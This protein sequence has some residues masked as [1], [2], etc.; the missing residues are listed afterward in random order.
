MRHLLT[1]AL[2]LLSFPVAAAPLSREE[3]PAPLR[4]W[5]SWVLRGHE[6]QTCPFYD[7]R[8]EREC[9][10]PGALKLT[11]D[12]SSGRFEQSWRVYADSRVLL[13]GGEQWP[14][15]V[16]V[17][18]VP[19]IVG[20]GPSILL[21][22]GS[23]VVSG[24]FS[25]KRLPE[26]LEVP[27]QTGLLALTVRGQAMPFPPRDDAGRLWLQAKAQPVAPKEQSHLE[28]SVHR[29]LIDE[30][31]AQLITRI[32]LKVSGA[33]REERLAR[34]L[35]EGFSPMSLVSPLPARLDGDGRLHPQARAG[36]WDLILV[37]RR[38]GPGDEIRM[39]KAEGAWDLDEA[40]VFEARPELRQADLE[41]APALD[42][43]QTELPM[44]WRSLPAYLVRP[45]D[46]LKLTQRR[47]GDDPPSPD[48][49]TQSREIWLD[50]DG[51]GYSARDRIAG[52]LGKSW[53]LEAA[54]ETKLG[55][56]AE[57]GL[58]QFLTALSSGGS[59]GLE[60]RTR[61]V[62]VE[63]DSRVEGRLRSAA[64]WRHDFESV[65]AVLHLPPGWRVFHASGADQASPTWV[66][67]WS[68]LDFFLVLV[69]AAAFLRLYGLNWG[70]AGL[71]GLGLSWHETGA[72]RWT[73]I[74]ILALAALHQALTAHASLERWTGVA[75]RGVWLALTLLLLPFFVQQI[76]QGMY[77]ALEFPY[78]TVEPGQAQDKSD[79]GES[80]GQFER[81]GRGGGA[82]NMVRQAPSRRAYAAKG[83]MSPAAPAAE[84]ALADMEMEE[85]AKAEQEEGAKLSLLSSAY[86]S[87]GERK[88][89][90]ASL[91]FYSSVVNQMRL[92]P[93]ARVSTGPGMPM[94]SWRSVRLSWKGPM[95]QDHRVRLWLLSPGVNLL[96]SMLRVGLLAALALLVGGWPVGA[97]LETL[98]DPEGRRRAARV[99][100][101]LLLLFV[102]LPVR[103][104]AQQFPPKD[105]LDDLRG[106]LLEKP[107]CGVNCAD[108][109]RLQITA[110]GGWLSLRLDVHAAAATAVPV[111]SGGREWTPSK[112]S[113]D[114]APAT[115]RRVEDGSLWAP[116]SA[117]AHVLVLEGPLPERDAV[118]IALPL[119]PHRVT[120]SV[121]GWVLNGVRDDGRA[122][123]NL[124][125]TRSRGAESTAAAAASARAQGIFPP[126]LRVERVV[127][128][129]LSWTVETVVTRLTPPGAPVVVQ[130]PLLPGESVTAPELRAI[131][132]K[133]AVNIAPQAMSFTWT[134]VLKETKELALASPASGP[135]TESWRVEPGPLWHVQA[136]G[137][138]PIYEEAHPGPRSLT[139]RPRPGE[140][141]ALQITRPAAVAGQTL[142]VDQ[143]VL[144]LKP[145]VRA[146]DASLTWSLRSSRGD[147]QILTLPEG[148]DLLSARIDGAAQPLR[149]EGR[150]L[151][152]PVTP[153][154]HTVDVEWRQ[155]G[156]ARMFYRAPEVDLGTPSVNSHV[157]V[158][159]PAGRWTLLLGGRGLGPAVLFWSLLAVFLFASVGLGK[160]GVTPLKWTHWFLLSLGLT[161]LSALGGVCVAGWFVAVG[162]RGA[163]PPEQRREFNL[164]Q[165]FLAALTA[166]AAVYLFL[167]IKR[168]LLGAPDMQISGNGSGAHL[169]RWY[170]DRAETTLPR[171]W[172]LSVP[173]FVYRAGML[174][175]ALWLADALTRWVRWA[176]DCCGVGGLWRGK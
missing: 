33:N 165:V 114:G 14:Q 94:W 31:P 134:S 24:T 166:A 85:D 171:P 136:S 45:G 109:P 63:A 56:V 97:W 157:R 77:P 42:P 65:G 52:T 170:L 105:L 149:L 35:P 82:L 173:L 145:G 92:D 126:F 87:S 43:Q 150:R 25:W 107:E 176:W 40:W 158:E 162:L 103:A 28:V 141:V 146:T 174:C 30:V 3:A 55:R 140:S 96:L 98:R 36:T 37:S 9:A 68:L 133:V 175:W 160:A 172:V 86:G 122:E 111:P 71:A 23:H 152:V 39:P 78:Q 153:G 155:P 142:T 83:M 17:D 80:E 115:L 49:L 138:A 44:D 54:P 41:G 81:A 62:Q 53:R 147:R 93:N 73:W 88:K 139:F 10:W 163:H 74:M 117:G 89:K 121:A 8:E 137:L 5:V 20:A 91:S 50:F 151:T 27:V 119:K 123:D 46:A 69:A 22:P 112:A 79:D 129:G 64:G 38:E 130:I 124:Q 110:T 161:Q 116:V 90:A 135:W 32:Q 102:L 7:G 101:P 11:L 70:L 113:L 148:S 106:R 159:M 169:L 84:A 60:V 128:L 131:G 61:Q 104:T 66:S 2:V 168:G 167:A 154:A 15:D 120:S 26:Q 75:R 118:Q 58:D 108:V 51:G 59:A 12:E 143:S 99:L 4:E 34:A 100:L 125:L 164:A 6:R 95:P 1:L 72:P 48:R 57:A 76:R 29:R 127:R 144:T 19:S 156:G 18:G 13:P 21:K 67:T 47:R 132:G 16:R